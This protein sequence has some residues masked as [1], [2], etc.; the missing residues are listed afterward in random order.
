MSYFL[1]WLKYKLH[2]LFELY[3]TGS[4]RLTNYS[5]TQISLYILR[6]IHLSF[7]HLI[8]FKPA[9]TCRKDPNF[10]SSFARFSVF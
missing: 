10:Q 7:L 4:S 8:L 3:F 5:T 9:L 1:L 2:L 6:V